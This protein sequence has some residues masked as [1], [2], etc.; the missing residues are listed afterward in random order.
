MHIKIMYCPTARVVFE[1]GSHYAD[2]RFNPLTSGSFARH[3][4]LNVSAAD[5][6]FFQENFSLND[7]RELRDALNKLL[8]E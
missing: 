6:T 1:T 8:P 3:Y 7:L 2:I 5:K 4:T